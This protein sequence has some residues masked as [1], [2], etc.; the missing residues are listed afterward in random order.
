MK[1]EMMTIV[2]HKEIVPRIFKMTLK[3]ELVKEMG[4]PG[5]FLHIKVPR[6]DMPLRRPISLAE[7]N[8][9]SSECVVIYRVEGDGTATISELP[10]GAQLD[11]MGPLGN[12]YD[13]SE[14]KEG[15]TAFVV[16][17][18]IGVPPLY[19]L[20]KQLHA[21]GV[22]VKAFLGF[23]DKDLI[24]LE[25]EFRAISDLV[26]VTDN[27]TNGYRAN[28]I[29]AMNQELENT[30]PDAVYACGAPGMLRVID[31]IFENHPAAYISMEARMACGM[32]ACYACVCKVKGDETGLK[33]KKVCD[34]GP[35]FKTGEVIV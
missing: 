24:F 16:G 34:Q 25:E 33:S 9:E 27:G 8:H 28:A 12:G 5:Q 35:V 14:V 30:N 20:T 22:K 11:V 7:I 3:G 17:G 26:V 13:I 2:G 1:Q 19:E 10:V 4:Q 31:S 15:Q 32:G 6:A 29:Q 18:G 23:Q 21:K